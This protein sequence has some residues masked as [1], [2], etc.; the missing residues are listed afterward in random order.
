M[1]EV[2]DWVSEIRDCMAAGRSES[3]SSA[4]VVVTDDD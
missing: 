4:A 2:T 3:L 1:S